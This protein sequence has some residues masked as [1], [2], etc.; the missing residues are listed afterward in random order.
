MVS[1]G[2]RWKAGIKKKS[3]RGWGWGLE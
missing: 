2:L 3:E 1:D